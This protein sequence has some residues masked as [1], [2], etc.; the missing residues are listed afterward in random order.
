MKKREFSRRQF[1]RKAAGTAVGTVGFPYIVASSALGKAGSVAASERIVMGCIG[2]GGQGTG[3]MR[4]FLGKADAQVVAVC[5]VIED[6]RQKAKGIVDRRYGDKGCASYNDFRDVLHR[7]DIDAVVI[8]TQDH[9]HA[10]IAVA[11]A[12]A[13]KDM[14]CEKPLGVAVVEGRAI[15]R[16][17]RT[18]GRVFQ[19][20]T[21]QRSDQKFRFACELARNGYLG[22]IHTVKV[23]APGPEYKRTYRKP[24]T[25]EP[26]PAGLDYDM[27]IG[28]APMKPY[29][30]GRLAWPDWYL[31]W[32]Y[33]AGFSVNW[34][35]HH[36]DIANWGC[37]AVSDEPFEFK[38]KGSHRD[39]GLTDNI[40]DWQAEFNYVSGLRMSFSDTGN[41]NKQGCQFEGDKGWVHVNRAGIRA[42][43]AS[44]LKVKI[45][46]DEIHLHESN[47]HHADFLNCVR[48]RSDPVSPV[49]AGHK[50]SNLGLITD[51]AARVNR[52]LKW[53][54]K[55]EVFV[56]DSEAD[57]FLSR[58]MRSPWHL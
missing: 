36:L 27:Y 2:V 29:N 34:G 22:K 5:D 8:V 19:T 11:A 23:A 14:Y 49:E 42:E 12:K 21:Q 37:P 7:P 32:D 46:P 1:L 26:I 3:N 25:E 50:A 54:P 28:P 31:I 16:A 17:V 9:W 40:N 58:P 57:R 56:N 51:I 4:G 20:G 53:D 39:D 45:K 41:P 30:G 47:N 52:R 18:Y 15:A 10:V 43:P 13:G 48:T 55:K 38:C 24:T 35:V 44:L 33:C 6:R